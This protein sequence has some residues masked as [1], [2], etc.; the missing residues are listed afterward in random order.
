MNR[1]GIRELA[2]T[3]LMMRRARTCRY[4]TAGR[5]RAP[6]GRPSSKSGACASSPASVQRSAVGG[7]HDPMLHEHMFVRQLRPV[8]CRFAPM[9]DLVTMLAC[10]AAFQGL[11]GH[12]ARSG[13]AFESDGVIA[14]IVPGLSE[15][16]IANA[17]VYTDPARL[18]ASFQARRPP[19]RMQASAARWSGPARRRR[20]AGRAPRGR[21]RARLGGPRDDARS[22][23]AAADDDPLDD[24]SD[25]P[26]PEEVA[27][28]VERSYGLAD[29]A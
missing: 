19:T 7:G 27:G 2:G 26:D 3:L 12:A 6:E 8:P 11:I 9:E 1:N 20:R 15:L 21:L 10:M 16:A 28:I 24:W 13:H 5:S 23:A 14:A 29:G 4:S 25:A 17:A 22:L 18:A